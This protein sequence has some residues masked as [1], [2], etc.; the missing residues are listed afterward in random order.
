MAFAH[1]SVRVHDAEKYSTKKDG[2]AL[3]LVTA[4][5]PRLVD[6]CAL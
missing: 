6:L 2:L 4:L 1:A 5:C 3:P